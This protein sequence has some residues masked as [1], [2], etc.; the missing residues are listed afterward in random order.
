[1]FGLDASHDLRLY[2]DEGFD[3]T[4]SVYTAKLKELTD[5]GNPVESRFYEAN[6]RQVTS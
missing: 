1:M 4:K 2:S 6:N 3:S 5:L